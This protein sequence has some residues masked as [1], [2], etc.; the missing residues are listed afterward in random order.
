MITQEEY[1]RV[2]SL[3]GRKGKPRPKT[4]VF[5]FT[6]LIRCGWCGAMVTA[7]EKFKHQK[8]GNVH[9]YIYYHCTHNTNPACT[10]K[11]VELQELARQVDAILS[12]VTISEAF[13]NWAI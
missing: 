2:Q 6:G 9:H 11:S 1:D 10:Q 13:K 8:N 7:E 5:A 4:H 3:L 12:I